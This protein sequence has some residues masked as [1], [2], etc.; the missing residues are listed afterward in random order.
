VNSVVYR[1][2]EDGVPPVRVKARTP[3]FGRHAGRLKKRWR[4]RRRVVLR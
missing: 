3:R 2:V 1:Y 4:S